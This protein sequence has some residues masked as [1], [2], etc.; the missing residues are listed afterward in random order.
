MVWMGMD[1]GLL[2]VPVRVPCHTQMGI[3]QTLLSFGL[4]EDIINIMRDQFE[5]HDDFTLVKNFRNVFYRW[6]F[7]KYSKGCHIL[8]Y[9]N[10]KIGR[11][12]LWFL[13]LYRC[14]QTK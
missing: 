6:I 7:L 13:V 2:I 5:S 10:H 1:N 9:L 3:I 14:W 8:Q 11:K 12:T 4:R